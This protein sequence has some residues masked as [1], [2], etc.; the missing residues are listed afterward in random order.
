MLYPFS[1]KVNKCI[2]NC[3]NISNQYSKVC[4]PN[5]VINIIAKVFHLMSWKNKT[6]Q[7]KWMKFVNVSVD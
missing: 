3:N 2:A 7:I 5:F 4:V 6:K 1:I